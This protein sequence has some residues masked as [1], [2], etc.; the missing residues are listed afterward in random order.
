L[1]TVF[2]RARYIKA[3]SDTTADYVWKYL[4]L[5]PALFYIMWYRITYFSN[6]SSLKLA[7]NP[8]NTIYLMAINLGAFL[9]YSLILRLTREHA[10]DIRLRA[11]YHALETR[12]LQYENLKERVSETRAARHDLRHHLTVIGGFLD[13]EDYKGLRKYLDDYI[14]K[15]PVDIP[16]Q[17]CENS[18]ANIIIVYF[19]GLASKSDITFTAETLIPEDIPISS[20]DLSVL[21][22]NL[23]EN[24]VEACHLAKEEH[25]FIRL[26]GGLRTAG[27][28]AL[29]IDN[30]SG[31]EPE[32]NRDGVFLSSKR[33]GA[34]IGIESV[35]SIAERYNGVTSFTQKDHVFYASVM[36][37]LN[38]RTDSS[39]ARPAVSGYTVSGTTQ[40]RRG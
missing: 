9:I 1:F 29:T 10:E 15:A 8:I 14:D 39:F 11:R 36:L 26:R 16:I 12:S 22:G 4:W 24:A 31:R 20:Q 33:P 40:S 13:R 2:Y 19:A 21:L 3:L 5:I 35:K 34:G 27:V 17:Y 30:S 6:E 38:D 28:F 7:L 18:A 37:S 23:L 25:P 32:K